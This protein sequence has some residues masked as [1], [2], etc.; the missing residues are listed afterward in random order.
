MT[1]KIGQF[2]FIAMTVLVVHF[3]L[4]LTLLRDSGSI[5]SVLLALL[6]AGIVTLGVNWRGKETSERVPTLSDEVDKTATVISQNTSKIAIGAA[7]VSY[8]IDGLNLSIENN[9]LHA[10]SIASSTEQL[11][12]TSERL[13]DNAARILQQAQEAENISKQGRQQAESGVLAI[14]NLSQDIDSAAHHVQSLKQ[15]AASIQKITDVINTVAQ[16]TNLLALNAA[17]EAARAGEQ[18][19]G[20]AVVADEVR[21][22]AGKTALATQDIARMLSEVSDETDTTSTLMEQVVS[23]TSQT[24]ELMSTLDSSFHQILS[25]NADAA[26]ALAQMQAALKETTDTTHN[27]SAAVS[28]IH[29]SLSQTAKQSH[30]VSEQAFDLTITTESIFAALTMF[31]TQTFDQ[32]VFREAVDAARQCG[33][34]LEQGLTAGTFTEHGLFSP[35]Y[36]PVP[37]THPTKY[38][39]DFDSYTDKYFPEVQE[40]ILRRH[41]EIVYAGAVDRKGYFPTHNQKFSQ[42]LTGK[43]EIDMIH[44]RTKRL[45]ND[46]T[47]I[48]CGQHTSSLLL[49]TYK[50]DTGEV[51]HDLSVPIYVRGKH[52]G[53]FR[54]GFKAD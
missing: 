3:V 8:F 29:D 1:S 51:M 39:T 16:Q 37:N 27:I 24:V 6:V 19:R 33:T 43:T 22:L 18:G 9:S 31:N 48:R 50:R 49:Q 28:A 12:H 36:K 40:A 34:L 44:N 35:L 7:E 32:Q 30:Q 25:S 26:H 21:G 53:G 46:P 4:L 54:I 11:S 47:G 45:F 17:I 41:K 10:S 52:W 38:V 42:R 23:R 2:V 13:S 5:Y 15:K 20:F 14:G